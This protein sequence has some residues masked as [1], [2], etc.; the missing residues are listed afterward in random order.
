MPLLAAVA[1]SWLWSAS[2]VAAAPLYPNQSL[3]NRGVDVKALQGL[4]MERGA[5][6]RVDGI[7]GAT[8]R[9]RGPRLPDGAW[10]AGHR[11]GRRAHLGRAGR[12]GRDRVDRARPSGAPAPA[13]RE[14]PGRPVV[15]GVFGAADA[16]AQC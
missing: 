14:A 16:I 6:I 11:P 12:P 13:Q 10:L 15:D 1:I 7:F 3:G 9:R 2:A 8:D 5:A 4:L